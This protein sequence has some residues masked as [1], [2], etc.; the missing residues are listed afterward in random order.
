MQE[1][2]QEVYIFV[3]LIHPHYYANILDIYLK[4]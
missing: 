2:Y 3:L 1:E 4:H